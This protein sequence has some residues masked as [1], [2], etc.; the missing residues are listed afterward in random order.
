VQ[1]CGRASKL[2]FDN[3]VNVFS[4]GGKR[5][6]RIFIR[7]EKEKQNYKELL[8]EKNINTETTTYLARRNMVNVNSLKVKKLIQT[9]ETRRGGG[10]VTR[11][12]CAV[13]ACVVMPLSCEARI[14]CSSG[15][16]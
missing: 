13:T 10:N 15:T 9:T 6:C 14:T 1:Y 2:D 8:T 3:M 12:P 4:K 5:L 16:C 11:T 7:Q